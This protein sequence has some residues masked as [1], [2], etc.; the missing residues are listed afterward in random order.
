[1][2]LL[3]FFA[4]FLPFCTTWFGFEIIF[5]VCKGKLNLLEMVGMAFPIGFSLCSILGLV[6][7]VIFGCTFIHY[8]LHIA[9]FGVLASAL[10]HVNK[11][12]KIRFN[13]TKLLTKIILIAIIPLS[14]YISLYIFPDKGY[15]L[16]ACEDQIY[17]EI[18]MVS[19]F[20]KG[21]NKW[22]GF[23]RGIINPFYSGKILWSDYISPFYCGLLK[24]A[25]MA[26]TKTIT[27]TTA[28]FFISLFYLQYSLTYKYTNSEFASC[29]AVPALLFAGGFYFTN[30]IPNWNNANRGL[31][32]IYKIDGSSLVNWGNGFLHAFL[33]SRTALLSCT[34]AISSYLLALAN[35]ETVGGLLVAFIALTR[36]QNGLFAAIIFTFIKFK[37]IEK[38]FAFL[39][40]NSFLFL[41][42]NGKF[43]F[44][45]P[46][47]SNG[48][49]KD[50]AIPV[51][52]FFIAIL[53]VFNFGIVL[54]LFDNR[55]FEIL[56]SLC[57]MVLLCCTNMQSEH[58]INFAVGVS[59]IYPFIIALSYTGFMKLA[60]M[61]K[62]NQIEGILFGLIIVTT[63]I[64]C[65]SSFCGI[66]HNYSLMTCV[67][68]D[69]ETE[70]EEWFIAN[71]SRSD[72][73]LFE[74]TIVWNPALTRAGRSAY[75]VPIQYFQFREFN[76]T[77]RKQDIEDFLKTKVWP[78]DVR[79]VVYK[80]GDTWERQLETNFNEYFNLVFNNEKYN[81]IEARS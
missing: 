61:F 29:L 49:T 13:R 40:V 39:A 47:W 81:I 8:I 22:R 26:V 23:V 7:N 38:R 78:E 59:V 19:S 30:I 73:I 41:L 18:T 65:L 25:G 56:V 42:E 57:A 1:M 64:G 31:D 44:C 43:T 27:F 37:K 10:R 77:D 24:S 68:E 34:L 48:V 71:S 6:F 75:Y 66:F 9:F 4:L 52:S 54:S 51:I 72:H 2:H 50:S 14:Y 63:V 70:V 33:S 76:T 69:D 53:G 11:K 15:V 28:L 62:D 60:R 45:D 5:F 21:E 58:R 55:S 32:Y 17:F 12:R 67:W 36:P 79:Y 3:G 35:F 80:S 46:L 20:S 74:P 16:K